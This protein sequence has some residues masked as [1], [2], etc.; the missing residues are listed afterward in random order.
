VKQG[1]EEIL[2]DAERLKI[3]REEI[4]RMLREAFYTRTIS[5]SYLRRLLPNEYKYD[6]KI[7]L[8]YKVKQKQEPMLNQQTTDYSEVNKQVLDVARQ[9]ELWT[10]I[11]ILEISW[12]QIPL[13][14]T[15]NP[16]ER[17]I[18]YVEVD[19][20]AIKNTERP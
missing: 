20:E 18:E 13:K 9:E 10:A 14:I 4:R 6:A 7:R 15:V 2:E 5:E 3:N 11:G 16:K 19:R 12:N 1:L 8:D 17:K